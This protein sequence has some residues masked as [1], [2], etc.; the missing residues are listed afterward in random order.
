MNE[1]AYYQVF[2]Y[3]IMY[4][5]GQIEELCIRKAIYSTIIASINSTDHLHCRQLLEA[6]FP[7]SRGIAEEI[8]I[9]SKDELLLSSVKQQIYSDS[10]YGKE[11]FISKVSLYIKFEINVYWSALSNICCPDPSTRFGTLV[12]RTQFTV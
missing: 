10:L 2:H 6:F 12:G 5:L 11:D 9:N 8:V 1:I 7:Q 4:F 3:L